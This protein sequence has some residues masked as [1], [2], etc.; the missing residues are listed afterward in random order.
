[1]IKLKAPLIPGPE[2]AVDTNDWCIIISVTI[3]NSRC[4]VEQNGH[5]RISWSSQT[6]SYNTGYNIESSSKVT[7]GFEKYGF[8]LLTYY[9]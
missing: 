6:Y 9:V 8:L 4:N 1:M 2:R 5:G 3:S 7:K